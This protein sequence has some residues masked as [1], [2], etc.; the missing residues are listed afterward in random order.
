MGTKTRSSRGRRVD[1]VMCDT[2]RNHP[3]SLGHIMQKCPAAHQ[4]RVTRHNSHGLG[5][6]QARRCWLL[7]QERAN[8]TNISRAASTRHH[9]LE[10][11][12]SWLG[13]KTC[14]W[15]LMPLQVTCI[16]STAE[17]QT[18]TSTTKMSAIGSET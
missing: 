4:A 10:A 1:S 5:H 8:H 18:I 16:S 15:W 11:G 9:S 12:P 14:R 2:C 6:N 3:E 13:D 7:Y 17:R